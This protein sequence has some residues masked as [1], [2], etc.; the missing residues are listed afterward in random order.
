MKSFT[1]DCIIIG[2]GPAGLTAAIYLQR[3]LRKTLTI[4]QNNAR[5]NWAPH[6]NNLAG[7]TRGISGTALLQR[8]RNQA[9][10]YNAEHICGTA[11]VFRDKPGFKV[12]V[13][14]NT[15]YSRFVILATGIKDR[16]PLIKNTKYLCKK[17]VLAYCPV[18]DGYDHQGK[19]IAVI[20]NSQIGFKKV[21]FMK[22]FS[23][24]IH[25]VVINEFKISA[26]TLKEMA[27]LNI[28]IH[29]G[30]LK[31]LNYQV[32]QKMLKIQLKNRKPL[33]VHLAYVELGSRVSPTAV[34]HLKNL[35]RSRGGRFLINQHQ[36][37]S[38][39]GLYAAGD[40]AHSL[41][42]VSVAAGQAA[43]AATDIH[44]RLRA[45]E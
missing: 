6:I 26:Q 41:A 34:R 31:S 28:T 21:K 36:Q 23:K 35:K 11:L 43:V 44:R 24:S 10:K 5:V 8:L 16:Q 14:E 30:V 3:F 13:G 39:T 18:C 32:K 17:M 9:S 25:A 37:T 15:F 20:I 27:I 42:Q 33:N 12:C 22:T 4:D 2:G 19:K 7:F 40:C 45:T 38:I 29:Q 1:H